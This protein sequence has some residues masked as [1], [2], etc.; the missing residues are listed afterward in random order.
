MAMI[1]QV[2]FD[3]P[4]TVKRA[5]VGERAVSSIDRVVVG[6]RTVAVVGQRTVVGQRADVV[7]QP[8]TPR[9]IPREG[10]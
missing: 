1:G 3:R 10:P 7:G 4:T 6:Q 9:P 2:A 5:A 8:P